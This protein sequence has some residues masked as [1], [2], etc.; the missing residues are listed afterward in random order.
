MMA[1]L[2]GYVIRQAFKEGNPKPLIYLLTVGTAAGGAALSLRDLAQSRGGEENDEVALRNRAASETQTSLMGLLDKMGIAP[3]EGS[4]GDKLLGW[5]IES[6]LATGGLG[7]LGELLH[8]SAEQLDNGAYG[9]ERIWSMILGP[10]FGTANKALTV[11]AGAQQAILGEEDKNDKTRQ[12]VRAIASTLPV[13]G[14]NAAFR[15]RHHR[16]RKPEE[17]SFQFSK[18]SKSKLIGIH[19]KL[20]EVLEDV[21]KLQIMDFSVTEGLRTKE[22]Q[23]ELF[24]TGKTKTMNSMHIIQE[25]GYGHA[26]DL[27]PSPLDMAKVKAGNAQ[28]ISRFGVLA[29]V[30]KAVAKQKGI[31]VRWGGDWDNDG[32]TLDHAFFDA[33]HMELG[34]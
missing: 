12:A 34:K 19:P 26:V 30:I 11:A 13:A 1:R 9:R 29:G 22:R 7:M 6:L 25:D 21:M 23:E 15:N 28:E 31:K 24:R 33:M 20:V 27:Y 4:G 16:R 10:S 3:E 8:N 32:E 18:L 2:S 5:Y 17:M 14:G